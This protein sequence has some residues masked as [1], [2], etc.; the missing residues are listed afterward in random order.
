MD[1][2]QT[3]LAKTFSISSVHTN[4]HRL[5]VAENFIRRIDSFKDIEPEPQTCLKIMEMATSIG[6]HYLEKNDNKKAL[7]YFEKAFEYNAKHSDTSDHIPALYLGIGSAEL[8]LNNPSAAIYYMK[9]FCDYVGI[10]MDLE[11]IS[12]RVHSAIAEKPDNRP[13]PNV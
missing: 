7:F 5:A 12:Q 8:N 13:F 6:Y 4:D 10:E 2:N 1:V 11:D 3:H 9:K